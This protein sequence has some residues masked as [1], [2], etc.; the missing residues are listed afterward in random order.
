MAPI[1]AWIALRGDLAWPPAWLGLAVLFWVTGFDVIYACQDVGFDRSQG[2][3]SI[4]ARL[5][6]RA[7]PC[8]W[9]RPAMRHDRRAR[10]PRAGPIPW[11]G[12]TSWAS[13]AVAVLLA[14]EHALVRPDDL[15][16]VNVAFFQVNI[17]I[18]LGI[19]GL[20]DVADLPASRQRVTVAVVAV[21]NRSIRTKISVTMEVSEESVERFVEGRGSMPTEAS[22]LQAIREKVEAGQRLSFE[23]G[24]GAGGVERPVRAGDDGEPGPRA[25]QR[26]FRLLQ[27]QHAHQPDE[28]L[29]L[30]VRLLRLPRRPRRSSR[31]R[32]GARPD[33][34]TRG[35]GARAGGDRAA[36]RRRACIT[37]C[38]ST[39]T[40]TWCAGSTRPIPRFTSRRTPASRSSSSP[41]SRGCRSSEV[42]RR[43]VDAGLG[44]LPGGGAEIFHPEVRERDLRRQG[45]DRDV[46]RGPPHGAPARAALERDDALRPHRE[47]QAPDRPHD[48]PP[49][50]SRTRPA[51]SRRSSRWRSTP[52]T[53]GWTRSP[54]PRA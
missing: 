6:V 21:A 29:R 27:R 47:G 46:A 37:S 35:P 12:S 19:A 7:T 43:L 9:R 44:S 14:Y 52:T 13:S 38:R 11:G 2:L 24:H 16:R 39:I 49:R 51:A 33:H 36:H 22:R 18:S 8:G 34:R 20:S 48:P 41:R 45:V 40:W 54:G 26:Q 3:H 53:R 10:R 1:A 17:A 32:D 23:D 5:G 15:T 31:L 50:R 30:Q 25:V 42:L 28:R 4:P